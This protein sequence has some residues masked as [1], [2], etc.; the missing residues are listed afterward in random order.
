MPQE[1]LDGHHDSV[2]VEELGDH[3]VPELV[4]RHFAP[5]LAGIILQALLDAPHRDSLASPS[6]L[7]HQ[8]DFFDSAGR[9]HPEIPHQGLIGIAGREQN[10]RNYC[11]CYPD[12]N[13]LFPS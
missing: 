1:I 8:E 5:R 6:P 9:P 2:S 13:I 10:V 12:I 11:S 3:G 4:A 7:I